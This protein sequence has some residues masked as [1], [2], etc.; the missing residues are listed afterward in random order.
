MINQPPVKTSGRVGTGTAVAILD[1]GVNYLLPDFGSCTSPGVPSTCKVVYAQDFAP[2]DGK[3][4]DDGMAQ[5]WQE[6]HSVLR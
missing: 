5:T 3:L 4:D 6:L 2:S 1:T